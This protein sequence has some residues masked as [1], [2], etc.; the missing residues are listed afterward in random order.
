[1]TRYFMTIPEA[2]SLVLQAATL[3]TEPGGAVFLLDMGAPISILELARSLC[4]AA[5]PD[6]DRARPCRQR[7]Q[8]S[9][10]G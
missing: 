7:R 3:E 2:A 9:E 5:W 4:T 10:S 6:A 8:A 1:M